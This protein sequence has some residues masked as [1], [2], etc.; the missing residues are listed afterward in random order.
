[1]VLGIDYRTLTVTFLPAGAY[2]PSTAKEVA[3]KFKQDVVK[4]LAPWDPRYE[5][6]AAP[7]SSW[8]PFADWE[9]KGVLEQGR[10]RRTGSTTSF[11]GCNIGIRRVNGDEGSSITCSGCVLNCGL[12]LI[13]N[14]RGTPMCVLG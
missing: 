12:T 7:A 4:L 9:P 14:F 6:P 10:L 8:S 1:M 3:D 5:P 2:M 13:I 11:A